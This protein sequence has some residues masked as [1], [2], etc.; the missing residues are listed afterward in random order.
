MA[1]IA[2]LGLA[3]NIFQILSFTM[4]VLSVAKKLYNAP[5]GTNDDD[6]HSLEFRARSLAESAKDTKR[7]LLCKPDRRRG[8]FDADAYDLEKIYARCE[9][10]K[11]EV[12][13]LLAKHGFT[14]PANKLH[15]SAS[16]IKRV[17]HD[18]RPRTGKIRKAFRC[19]VKAFKTNMAKNEISKIGKHLD[20]IQ[21]DLNIYRASL[22]LRYASKRE[23]E[24]TGFL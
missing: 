6:W 21:N 20:E 12:D 19:I 3:S 8:S 11:E 10:Y 15:A 1:E 4:E 5:D 23:L 18:L 2:A 7:M 22:E 9:K 14:I 24:C 17:P 16:F 13:R